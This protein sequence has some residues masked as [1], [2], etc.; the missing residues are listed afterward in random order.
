MK[1]I[2]AAHFFFKLE[3][4]Q[5]FFVDFSE[6]CCFMIF[7][8]KIFLVVIKTIVVLSLMYLC[9]L[10]VVGL[11]HPHINILPTHYSGKE[12]MPPSGGTMN[13]LTDHFTTGL[14]MY[15]KVLL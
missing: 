8:K 9:L 5:F 13:C 15:I 11:I 4:E 3:T 1:I 2:W 6:Y 12:E 14:K 7:Q 10:N